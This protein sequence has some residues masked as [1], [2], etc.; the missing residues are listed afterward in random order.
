MNNHVDNGHALLGGGLLR[1][2]TSCVDPFAVIRRL[3]EE[4]HKRIDVGAILHSLEV[5]VFYGA[6]CGE[7]VLLALTRTAKRI[8]RF[9]GNPV[10]APGLI[11]PSAIR[12]ASRM[13][14]PID[15]H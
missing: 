6:R 11:Y 9:F 2:V 10:P 13:F 3:R 12:S 1:R 7:A 8:G 15:D 14:P 5:A 4:A